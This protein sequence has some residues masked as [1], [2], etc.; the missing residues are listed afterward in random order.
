[1]CPNEPSGE[2]REKTILGADDD[3]GGRVKKHPIKARSGVDVK[4]IGITLIR[5]SR[6]TVE[7]P[8][9]DL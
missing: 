2:R 1:M 8:I 5:G 9:Q 4:L 3:L 6:E 7:E